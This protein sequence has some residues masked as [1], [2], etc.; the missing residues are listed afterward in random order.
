MID[1]IKANDY[2][3]WDQIDTIFNA[4]QL[5]HAKKAVDW[6]TVFISED[7]FLYLS[8]YS[9]HWAWA[10]EQ[11]ESYIEYMRELSMQQD[12]IDASE[13]NRIK[14]LTDF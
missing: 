10:G 3:H 8:G 9:Y 7:R 5:L 2:I 13:I 12:T 4:G 6:R 14:S 11:I 1:A